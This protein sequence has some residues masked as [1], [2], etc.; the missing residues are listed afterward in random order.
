[1]FKKT[2]IYIARTDEKYTLKESGPCVDCTRVLKKLNIK[3]IVYS[4]D[5]GYD[6]IQAPA[7]HQSLHKTEG[8]RFINKR[9]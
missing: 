5:G 7:E 3:K 6:V 4:T 1:M 2:I 8:R 9:M